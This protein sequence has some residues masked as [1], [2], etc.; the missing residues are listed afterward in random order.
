MGNNIGITL[1]EL[2]ARHTACVGAREQL[3]KDFEGKDS[4]FAYVLG[5]LESLIAL[6]EARC[7]APPG[8]PAAIEEP[9]AAAR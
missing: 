1:D 8:A 7:Q 3:R 4:G 6:V 9:A 2:R 5:E